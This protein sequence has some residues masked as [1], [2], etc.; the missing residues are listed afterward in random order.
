MATQPPTSRPRTSRLHE[1]H[2]AKIVRASVLTVSDTRTVEDDESGALIEQL[3]RAAGHEIGSRTVVKDDRAAIRRSVQWLVSEEV[4]VLIM[5]GGTG[6]ARRDVTCESIE[7]LLEKRLE[8]FGEAFRRLSW[9]QIGPKAILS[10][11]TAGTM[12]S[13]L[14]FALPGSTKAVRLAMEAI[15]LPVLTHAVG[16]MR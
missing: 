12:G 10:R 7:S 2:D 5:T 1:A 15:I 6:I 9:D 13:T 3:L 16:L 14:L 11:A 4:D 8:G